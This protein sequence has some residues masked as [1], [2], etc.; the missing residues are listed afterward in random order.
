MSFNIN[1]T[2]EIFV[3]KIEHWVLGVI[4]YHTQNRV[5]V[6]YDTRFKDLLGSKG[7][8]WVTLDN[9]AKKYTNYGMDCTIYNPIK[10]GLH[11]ISAPLCYTSKNKRNLLLIPEGRS[12]GFVM[13]NN[14][15]DSSSHQFICKFPRIT[16]TCG[17]FLAYASDEDTL[18]VINKQD[19][20]DHNSRIALMSA[21]ISRHDGEDLKWKHRYYMMPE[22]D[23]IAFKDLSGTNMVFIG[24][25]INEFHFVKEHCHFKCDTR[26]NKFVFV[27]M[28]DV[29]MRKL[30]HVYE[31]KL[32]YV[33][34]MKR[35]FLFGTDYIYCCHVDN[36]DQKRYKWS[37]FSS[38]LTLTNQQND[39]HLLLVFEHIVFLYFIGDLFDIYCIDLHDGNLFKCGNC[40]PIAYL[41]RTDD[42]KP[43]V[44]ANNNGIVHFVGNMH[45]K[46]TL[47][48]I[49]PKQIKDK[50]MASV[51][52][53]VSN[54][55]NQHHLH[56]KS[57]P[58]CISKLILSFYS[59]MFA[60]IHGQL[61]R[62]G[63]I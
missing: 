32:I 38:K 61:G 6:K 16:R 11:T 47:N 20:I 55:Q 49:V 48:D 42:C 62:D 37:I 51:M 30:D 3:P 35:M 46:W 7:Y 28:I 18:Y 63:N 8:G 1:E 15:K 10:G 36:S 26:T 22:F 50:Q 41:N 58:L 34:S 27:G 9:I 17:F 39:Y 29:C 14:D 4:N 57:I 25:P 54:V 44:T 13:Y 24:A 23:T 31:R 59:S 12:H 2:V 52:A 21:C 40:S 33:E 56:T 5:C 60:L 19:T 43:Y 53:F 45:Y